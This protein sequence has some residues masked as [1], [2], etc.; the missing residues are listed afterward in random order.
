MIYTTVKK[1]SGFSKKE[2]TVNPDPVD[3]HVGSRLR[4]RRAMVGFSQERLAEAVGLTFQ[5]VQKYER[6]TNRVSASRLYQFGKVLEVPVGYFFEQ[7]SP[8]RKTAFQGMSDNDQE[9]LQPDDNK[10]NDRETETLL[11]TYYSI[12]DA[13]KRKDLMKVIKA[14][15]ENLRSEK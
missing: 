13:A 11:R 2:G 8:T 14:M 10:K 5:Q 12:Q 4:M 15:A 6:G 7:Y 3:I 1:G 9:S